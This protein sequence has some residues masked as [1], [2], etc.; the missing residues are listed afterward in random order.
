MRSVKYFGRALSGLLAIVLVVAFVPTQVVAQDNDRT[1]IQVRT[2]HVKGG[3]RNEWVALQKQLAEAM[4][5]DGRPGR[6]IWQEYVA[7]W[8]P[9]TL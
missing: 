6:T 8:A 7:I 5:A 4:K 1:Y 9:S 2:A 3:M